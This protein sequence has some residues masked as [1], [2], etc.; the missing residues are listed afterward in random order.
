MTFLIAMTFVMA[1][2][3]FLLI[4]STTSKTQTLQWG[5]IPHM[6]CCLLGGLTGLTLFGLQP[7]QVLDPGNNV[8][9]LLFLFGMVSYLLFSGY[10]WRSVN[11]SE[12]TNGMLQIGMPA[13][14]LF[15]SAYLCFT[16]GDHWEFF[17]DEMNSGFVD[18]SFIQS[19]DV[20]C[21]GVVLVQFQDETALYRCPSTI[22]LGSRADVLF[23]PWPAYTQG[24]SRDLRSKME[25]MMANWGVKN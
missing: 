6:F 24:T 9:S 18:A 17:K 16:V 13:L 15:C 5:G 25:A 21:S 2:H 23:V 7:V 11:G 8:L 3:A 12:S 19:Q 1:M 22:V 20:S 14:T 4:K 10:L